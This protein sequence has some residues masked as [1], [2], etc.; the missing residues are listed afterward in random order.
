MRSCDAEDREPDDPLTHFALSRRVQRRAAII[1]ILVITVNGEG[2]IRVGGGRTGLCVSRFPERDRRFRHMLTSS[3][4]CARC[5]IIVIK[6]RSLGNAR[7]FF[8]I[9]RMTRSAHPAAAK[10]GQ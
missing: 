3:S 7:A 1:T 10:F 2:G 6:R 9:T 4:E 5:V 8:M